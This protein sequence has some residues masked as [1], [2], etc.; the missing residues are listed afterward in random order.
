M[1]EVR[2]GPRR[3][4]Q[5]P[6]QHAARTAGDRLQVPARATK[7]RG[8]LR[9]HPRN[10][11]GRTPDRV[12]GPAHLLA[13]ITGTHQQA[14]GVGE[15]LP[16]T[17]QAGPE[18]G[19]IAL[20]VQAR[21]I[22]F[23][24]AVRE[25][26]QIGRAPREVG[27]L[28][29][30]VPAGPRGD[31]AAAHPHRVHDHARSLPLHVHPEEPHRSVARGLHRQAVRPVR[32]LQHG[33]ARP[34]RAA[35][36]NPHGRCAVHGEI[37]VAPFGLQQV[38]D[39]EARDVL[40]LGVGSGGLDPTQARGGGRLHAHARNAEH[41]IAP[42]PRA[43]VVV[44]HPGALGAEVGVTG[45]VSG[46]GRGRHDEPVAGVAELALEL[47]TNLAG[48]V[49]TGNVGCTPERDADHVVPPRHRV[50][51][52]MHPVERLRS[53]AEGLERHL[54]NVV[55]LPDLQPGTVL[56]GELGLGRRRVEHERAHRG[57]VDGR[58]LGGGRAGG[59]HPR[60]LCAPALHAG[61]VGRPVRVGDLDGLDPGR[62]R[63]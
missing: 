38:L 55:H 35:R 2:G 50:V 22:R 60:G 40:A 58:G 44:A 10:P 4:Q 12:G 29:G 45:T 47:P 20:G 9:L 36:G 30:G 11:C 31:R 3:I 57:D 59:G 39:L 19:A 15:H 8:R 32:N 41:S 24:G 51:D 33:H 6:P 16:E 49:L 23:V 43:P 56:G 34:R 18:L 53:A 52:R 46:P 61:S 62:L 13:A 14:G 21:I 27:S 5:T 17:L 63:G 26:R 1:D 25:H 28:E 37:E 54:R 7:L 42:A 48:V